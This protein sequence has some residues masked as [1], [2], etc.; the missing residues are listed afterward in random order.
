[1]N[2]IRV[3]DRLPELPGDSAD[4][5][6]GVVVLVASEDGR[7][8][9]ARW[10]DPPRLGRPPRP[11]RWEEYDGSRLLQPVVTHWM[12]LPTHPVGPSDGAGWEEFVP[13]GWSGR[14]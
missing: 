8:L 3:E 5:A 9:A 13:P 12:P 4:R 7:V 10:V 11:P 14:W 2:W 1:V 6:V